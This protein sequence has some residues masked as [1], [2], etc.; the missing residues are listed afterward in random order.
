MSQ[1]ATGVFVSQTGNP[2]IDGILAGSAWNGPVTYGFPTSPSDY[3]SDYPNS[4]QTQDFSPLN[5]VQ[6]DAV[7]TIL[8][9]AFSST[10]RGAFSVEGF[11]N[12]DFSQESNGAIA[13]MRFANSSQANPTA[14]AYYPGPDNN[15][16][17]WFGT[18]ATNGYDAPAVGNY[19][20]ATFL[21]EI[22]HALGLK[23]GH[24]ADSY[25]G[26][27]TA[28]A[29]P[30]QY[31][32]TE[33]TVMTYRS[34]VGGDA[35][36]GYTNE[37]GGYPQTYMMLDIAALQRMYGADY[38][39]NAGDTVYRWTPDSGV[40][41]INGE[42]VLTPTDNRI[43]ATIWDG[44][45]TD[46]YDLS[47]YTTN[48][49]IDLNP[50][51]HSAFSSVQLAN[52]GDNNGT[53]VF[54][55]GNSYNALLFDGDTRSLIEN[56]IGGSGAD[57]IQGNQAANTLTGNAGDDQLFGSTGNDTLYGGEGNDV[58]FGGT[59]NDVLFGGTGN[60]AL[61]GGAGVDVV[62]GGEGNDTLGGGDDGDL[63]GGGAGTD[64]FYSGGG[65][66][67]VYGGV[68]ADTLYGG[69]GDDLM[70]GG[71]ASDV[72][73][74]GAGNDSVYGGEGNDVLG[75]G[76]GND[77]LGGGAGNDT[78]FGGEGAD[79]LYG[80]T[81]SDVFYGGAGNDMIFFG[82][83]DGAQDTW[84]YAPGGGNDTIT[85]F[86]VANDLLNL[87]GSG[88]TNFSQ[89]QAATVYSGGTATITFGDGTVLTLENVGTL[90]ANDVTFNPQ[91]ASPEF[92]LV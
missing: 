25:P 74:A 2:L 72:V 87:S 22:G 73:Y 46:T 52:L 11:T 16:D 48:L 12:L 8:D 42:A 61:Y 66:D 76:A 20:W 39:A 62:F 84:V 37:A 51:S 79:T 81:G 67:S 26:G 59:D 18:D 47:A 32:T 44:G 43:F 60:D 78:L 77:V 50:G 38:T 58:L 69:S 63:L 1:Y 70:F 75:G 92:D 53:T 45:G 6:T 56:A 88:F 65:N 24:E 82:T 21:H 83:G 31:D 3:P 40:T 33:Y 90:Q 85:G 89:V 14:Y 27:G 64:V 15:G 34:F 57:T 71:N 35:V 30:T 80:G 7:R 86:D 19:A 29:L 23:H 9:T 41:S 91:A 13:D 68:D 54:A 49:Q 55:S 17:T 36:N 28:P 10:A 5:Q 4:P